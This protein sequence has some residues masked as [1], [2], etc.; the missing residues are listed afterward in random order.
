M[1]LICELASIYSH[2][3]WLAIISKLASHMKFRN[4]QKGVT[5]LELMVATA[6]FVAVILLATNIYKDVMEG[7]RSAISSQD[8]QESMRYAFE[9]M[10]KEIRHAKGSEANPCVNGAPSDYFTFNTNEVGFDFGTELYF[11]NSSSTCVKYYLSPQGRLMIGRGTPYVDM[12]VSP[13]EIAVTNLKFYIRDY[14]DSLQPGEKF[15][16]S[17]TMRLTAEMAGS[18]AK[19]KQTMDIQTTVSSRSYRQ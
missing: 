10:S 12:P 6:I 17:V 7:Q 3:S 15:Q 4:N 11:Q 13:D 14:N 5:L 1:M 2:I 16:P 18:Q 19:Y 8:V 9:V